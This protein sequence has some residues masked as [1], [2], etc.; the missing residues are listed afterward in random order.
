MQE[1]EIQIGTVAQ[2]PSAQLAITDNRKPPP[3][4]LVQMRWLTIT[5]NHLRPRLLHHSINHRLRQPCEV[6]AHFHHRQRTG[7]IRRRN[8]QKLCLFKLA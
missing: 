5:R 2:L 8:P 4:A 6:I 3:L 1:D 7:N